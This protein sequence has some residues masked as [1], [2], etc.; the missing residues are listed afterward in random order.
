[1]RRIVATEYVTVD[2]VMEDPGGGEGTPHGGWSGAFFDEQIG[3]YKYEELTSCDAQLLGR[4]TYEEFS[5]AWPAM[6]EA[7]HPGLREFA[8]VMNGMPKH[9]ASRTTSGGDLECDGARLRR[10]LRRARPEGAGRRRHP[11][12]RRAATSSRR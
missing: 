10:G 9:V 2:G 6:A 7:D 3:A 5:Q 11:A 12:C 8:A 1:M 4:V